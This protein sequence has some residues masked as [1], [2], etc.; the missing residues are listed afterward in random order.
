MSTTYAESRKKMDPAGEQTTVGSF[1]YKLTRPYH[2]SWLD[3]RSRTMW[4]RATSFEKDVPHF[5]GFIEAVA[6]GA[7]SKALHAPWADSQT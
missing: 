3:A 1:D 4:G 5:L 2:Y 7:R 6:Y